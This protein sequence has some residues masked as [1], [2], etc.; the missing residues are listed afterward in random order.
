[1]RDD[2]RRGPGLA[3][4]LVEDAQDELA[5]LRVQ[6]AGRLV[7]QEELGLLRHRARDRH[8]LLLAAGELRREV[9][10]PVAEPHQLERLLGLH[11][12]GRD[13]ADQRDV[14]PG[15]Q[16]GDEVVELEDEADELAPV[17]RELVVVGVAQVQ[18]LV[19]QRPVRGTVEPADD[20]EQ[21]RL[22]ASGRA[23]QDDELG[24]V[25]VEIDRAEGADLDLAHVVDLREAPR[26]EDRLPGH[27]SS[28][29]PGPCVWRP[30]AAHP[31]EGNQA[32]EPGG[33]RP[34]P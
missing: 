20:V 23:E 18:L 15:G 14:L 30:G 26:L 5:R 6:R 7:A 2:R 28:P 9:V 33:S 24:V 27:R 8:A 34:R 25:Q 13:L 31:P 21:R 29:T 1:M 32:V 11:R 12:V 19:A 16:A 3:V 22:A 10:E 17:A 4:D